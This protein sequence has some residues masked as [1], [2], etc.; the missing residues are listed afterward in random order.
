MQA[1]DL[2]AL[3]DL[4]EGHVDLRRRPGSV[5]PVRFPVAELNYLDP[6]TRWVATCAAGVRLRLVTDSRNLR[7]SV[8][9]RQALG[10]DS[11]SLANYDLYVDGQLWAR[12]PAEG[13]AR[14][15][16]TGGFEGDERAAIVF[17]GLPAGERSLERER[18]AVF[19][20]E[21]PAGE[22]TLELWLPQV[23]TVSITR[24]E[25]DDGAHWA[26]WPDRRRRLVFHGSS[27][28]H[29]MEADGA[30]GAW[31]AV[32]AGLADMAHLNL[33]WAGSC[34]LS[35]LAARAIRDQ[36]ADG[37][38]L[39]LGINVY[40]EG[41]LKERTFLD[42]AHSMISI[43]REKHPTTPLMIVSPIYS[44]SRESEGAAGGPSLMRMRELLEDVV[45]ARAKTGDR[46]IRYLSGLALFDEADAPDLPDDLHPNAAGYRRMGERFYE[47]ALKDQS[48][49]AR[50]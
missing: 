12:A 3:D 14:V 45:E 1:I 13:G 11:R 23:A 16:M 26:P 48:W 31:P 19:L 28:S 18:G 35:G 46:A 29:C 34:L 39:K 47:I 24:L 32:A 41:M 27:I 33:G 7:L 10:A 50:T 43:I 8:T 40:S 2:N 22:K 37:I 17:S 44:A 36:P 15:V 20:P 21:L 6:A 42:S 4:V 30:S 5:Q 49:L 25:L 38:V 9:Q